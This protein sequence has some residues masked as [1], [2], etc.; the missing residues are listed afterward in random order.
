MSQR[1]FIVCFLSFLKKSK[2]KPPNPIWD[3]LFM[4]LTTFSGQGE[5]RELEEQE[6]PFN[7]IA[8]SQMLYGEKPP[9]LTEG[10]KAV[11]FV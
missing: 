11:S 5:P 7:Y 10:K 3:H 8:F 6:Q 9:P 2:F 1:S 4:T